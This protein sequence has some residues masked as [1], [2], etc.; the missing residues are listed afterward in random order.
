MKGLYLKG[1]YM[2][3]AKAK[4]GLV[5]GMGLG[6]LA[7]AGCTV[8]VYSPPQQGTVVIQEG[9]TPAPDEAVVEAPPPDQDVVV[10]VAPGPD[11]VWIGG[12]WGWNGGRYVWYGGHW[13]HH[14]YGRSRWVRG[15]WNHGG[16]GYVF[17]RGHW[18]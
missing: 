17:V 6:L 8:D 11:Y 5:A 12:Y 18:E 2:L 16:H 10:G 3:N 9:G 1:E 15:Y 4:T 7:A 14:P 13:D